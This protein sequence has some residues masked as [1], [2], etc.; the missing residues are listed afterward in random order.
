M[1]FWANNIESCGTNAACR[2]EKRVDTSAAFF[3]SIEFQQTGFLVERLY[4]SA[5]NR[6]PVYG[7]FTR[8][9]QALGREVIVGQGSWQIQLETNKQ[10]FAANFV[11]RPDFIAAYGGLSNEQYVDALNVNTAGSLTASDRNALVAGLSGSTETRATVLRK[12]AENAVFSEHEFNR[13]FVLMQYFG[14]LRRNPNDSPDLD[15]SGYSFWLGKLNLFGGDFRQAEMVKAFI[16]SGEY[17][18]RFAQ[19]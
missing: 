1:A 3:L 7:E 8:D 5:L 10:Q 17:R 15:F 12:V 18:H 16:N 19:Q 4:Q 14:Y 9:R 13:A 2:A 11:E 6:F